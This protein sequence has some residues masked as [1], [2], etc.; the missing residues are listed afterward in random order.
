MCIRDRLWGGHDNY[1]GL[2]EQLPDAN[3]DIPGARRQIEQQN[4]E[5]T[6]PHITQKLFD[7]AMPVS[8]THL[9]VYKRQ[10]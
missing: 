5:V 10:A 6:E 2:G 4:I 3:R 1:L 7:G 8:Y 9:D